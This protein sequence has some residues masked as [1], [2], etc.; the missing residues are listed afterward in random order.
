[1]LPYKVSQLSPTSDCLSVYGNQD[2]SVALGT[3]NRSVTIDPDT[4]SNK[5]QY[6]FLNEGTTN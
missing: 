5:N 6:R 3:E 1:V 2:F 4:K